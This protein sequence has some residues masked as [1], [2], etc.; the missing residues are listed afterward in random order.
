MK[1]DDAEIYTDCEVEVDDIGLLSGTH[2]GFYLAWA[3]K[4]SLLAN[5]LRADAEAVLQDPTLGRALLFNR[6]DGKLTS[7]DLNDRGNAFTQSYYESSYMRDYVALFAL[8]EDDPAALF[9]VDNTA[10]NYAKVAQWLDASFGE[11]QNLAALPSDVKLL[12]LMEAQFAPWLLSQGFIRDPNA[13][14]KEKARY[15]KTGPWGQHCLMLSALDDRP[16]MY[17]MALEVSSTFNT[18]ATWVRDEMRIDN[19]RI[20]SEPPA[21]YYEPRHHW[22]GDWPVPLIPF[23]GGPVH[24]IPLTD[25]R[26]IEPAI[27]IL[28]RRAQKVLPDLLASLENLDGYVRLY[29]GDPARVPEPWRVKTYNEGPFVSVSYLTLLRLLCAE[30]AH[31]PNL[32]AMCDHAERALDAAE[33]ALRKQMFGAEVQEMRA[34]L[35]RLRAR[36]LSR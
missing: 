24:A 4:N 6:C 10:A 26:Q 27:G 20:T 36:M 19:P 17:S 11:W 34:R 3:V 31:H 22:L 28:C 12:Q 8:D 18:L 35:M 30:L 25:V 2:I 21:T 7:D 33:P 14:Y 5:R 1:Y 29:C 13:F 15:I 16:K 23:R 9:K 32:R